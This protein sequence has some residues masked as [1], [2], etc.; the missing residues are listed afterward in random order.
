MPLEFQKQDKTNFAAGRLT[1]HHL[2]TV[3][4]WARQQMRCPGNI[5]L[6][7]TYILSYAIEVFHSLCSAL[8]CPGSIIFCSLFSLRVSFMC[9]PLSRP[10]QDISIMGFD[11]IKR[12]GSIKFIKLNFF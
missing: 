8:H 12:R 6:N 9:I 5:S 10:H 1:N 4:I 7:F 2:I 11:I 3:R